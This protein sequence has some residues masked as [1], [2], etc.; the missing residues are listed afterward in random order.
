MFGYKSDVFF[1]KYNKDFIKF[2]SNGSKVTAYKSRNQEYY[3]NRRMASTLREFD[4]TVEMV[5]IEYRID[6]S[7]GVERTAPFVETVELAPDDK[8]FLYRPC[9]NLHCTGRGFYL[10]DEIE[11]AIRLRKVIGGELHCEGKEDWKYYS[12]PK[13]NECRTILKYKITP[14]MTVF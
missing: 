14:L 2:S 4:S 10:T 11:K 6:F 5:V 12:Y 13:G 3:D 8:L 7:T 9:A 1:L